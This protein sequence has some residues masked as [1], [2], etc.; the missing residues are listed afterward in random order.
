MAATASSAI[1]RIWYEPNDESLFVTF[2]G[3]KTYIYEGV[4]GQL[5]RS[6]LAA[7]SRGRFFNVHIRDHYPHR[8]VKS[9]QTS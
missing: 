2:V 6:F 1:L 7:D 3:G 8:L 4:P 5:C 9:R